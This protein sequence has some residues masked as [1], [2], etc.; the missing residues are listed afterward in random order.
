[1]S[2]ETPVIPIVVPNEELAALEERLMRK[3]LA[4]VAPE[5]VGE[6]SSKSPPKDGGPDQAIPSTSGASE[7]AIC[8][9]PLDFRHLE[10]V[11][12]DLAQNSLAPSTKRTYASGQK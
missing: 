5:G 8:K 12:R 11:A 2:G 9:G 3:I 10:R 1:M 4:K 7:T 6:G